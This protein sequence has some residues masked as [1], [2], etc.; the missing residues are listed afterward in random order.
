MEKILTFLAIGVILLVIGIMNFKG[1]I[2]T[3][4]RYHRKRVKE[5]DVPAFGK[6]IGTGTIICAVSLMVC[7]V[8]EF[9]GD[10]LVMSSI[11]LV[12]TVVMIS[13]LVIG[14]AIILFATIKYNKG[15]F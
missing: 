6:L 15:I 5:E 13:G 4:H 7:G 2:S 11:S 8:L 9:I 12:G 14:L 10:T 1:N 3:L